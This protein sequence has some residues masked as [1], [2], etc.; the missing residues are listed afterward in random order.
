MSTIAE[1]LK[2]EFHNERKEGRK[3]GIQETLGSI[4]KNMLQLN[5]DDKTI[6]KFTNAK[7]EDIEK[8]KINLG[9]LAK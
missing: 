9:M 6:M 5:Q 7:K 8:V 2:K 3:E 1:R 4:I